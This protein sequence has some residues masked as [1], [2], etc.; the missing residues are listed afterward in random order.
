MWIVEPFVA[1]FDFAGGKRVSR[2]GDGL[3][4]DATAVAFDKHDNLII[5]GHFQERIDLSAQQGPVLV[6][7]PSAADMFRL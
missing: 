5:A 1:Y 2:F 3:E 4:T 7:N 6:S